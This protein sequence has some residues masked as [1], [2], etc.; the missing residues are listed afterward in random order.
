MKYYL[1]IPFPNGSY[2]CTATVSAWKKHVVSNNKK[3]HE[4][5]L[6]P[7]V[8]THQ[9]HEFSGPSTLQADDEICIL[10]YVKIYGS[11]CFLS[12]KLSPTD[13]DYQ[14]ISLSDVVAQLQDDQL[15][16]HTPIRLSIYDISRTSKVTITLDKLR[17]A[18]SEKKGFEELEFRKSEGDEM[19]LPQLNQP[20]VLL[21][22]MAYSADASQSHEGQRSDA[23]STEKAHK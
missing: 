22:K 6:V 1:Y 15:P 10:G 5:Q 16:E 12:N 3:N 18:F 9:E 14:Q 7:R 17:L 21:K 11:T 13:S 8:I 2:E 23:F 19:N 4:K 20:A